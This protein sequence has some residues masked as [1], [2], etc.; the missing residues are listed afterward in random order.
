[1]FDKKLFMK[2]KFT[3]RE[4]EVDVPGLAAFFGEA[5]PVWTVRGLTGTELAIVNSAA[6][7]AKDVQAVVDALSS[8]GEK[9]VSEAIKKLLGFSGDV[10]VETTKRIELLTIGSVKPEITREVAVRLSE[11]YPIEMQILTGAIMKLTGQG[12]QPGKLPG[13]GA[14]P[15]SEPPSTSVT[16]G[17]D[18]SS[19]SGPTSS[20]KGS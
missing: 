14:T 2:T 16:P 1:M 7:T 8:G 6:E 5:P 12:K 18:S 11:V 10:P 13:S 20:Q 3:A 17:G 4:Q 19:K 15:K 9:E